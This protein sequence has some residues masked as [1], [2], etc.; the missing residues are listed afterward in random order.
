MSKKS[1]PLSPADIGAI[2]SVREQIEADRR[3]YAETG[4]WPPNAVLDEVAEMRR[5]AWGPDG[6]EHLRRLQSYADKEYARQNGQ[7]PHP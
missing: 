5:R 3:H 4:E 7:D 1:T 6:N 2:R